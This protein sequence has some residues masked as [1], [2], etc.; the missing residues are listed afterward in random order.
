[1]PTSGASFI[2][3]GCQCGAVRYRIRVVEDPSDHTSDTTTNTTRGDSD[4]RLPRPF[5][6]AEFFHCRMCQKAF[7]NAGAALASVPAGLV[8]WARGPAAPAAFRSSSVVERGFCPRC[9]TPLYMREDGDPNC[10]LAVG[11]LDDPGLIRRLGRQVGVESKVPWFDSISG[12]PAETT[13]QGWA[14]DGM[15]DKLRSLQHPDRDTAEDDN[16]YPEGAVPSGT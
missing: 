11:A 9:G 15:A 8:D 12:L 14:S 4:R 6:S 13:D 1:M 3:G 10:E 16:N 2:G 7:G 5:V